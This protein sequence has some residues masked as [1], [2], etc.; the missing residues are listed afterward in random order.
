VMLTLESKDA[1]YVQTALE[2]LLALL[3]HGS[4]HEAR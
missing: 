4:V 2:R 3:P 1:C